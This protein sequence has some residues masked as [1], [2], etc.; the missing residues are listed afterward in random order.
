MSDQE[1][2]LKQITEETYNDEDVISSPVSLVDYFER[3]LNEVDYIS[4]K[5]YLEN[6]EILSFLLSYNE[7]TK[8]YRATV[9]SFEIDF[10]SNWSIFSEF[11][12][13]K[14][15]YVNA[16]E[17]SDSLC[18][19]FLSLVGEVKFVVLA[20]DHDMSR[21]IFLNSENAVK[22]CAWIEGYFQNKQAEEQKK[23]S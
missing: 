20:S 2:L 21:L 12:D 10:P 9:G 7:Q 15:A 3:R 22:Q 23:A 13:S 11:H 8:C 4:L 18:E 16:E 5:A 17:D 1:L 14:L 6:E 19:V